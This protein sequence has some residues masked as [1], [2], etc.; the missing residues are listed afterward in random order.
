MQRKSII[1]VLIGV[2]IILLVPAVAMQ[3]T[4]EV[5]WA[6]FDF[7]AASALLISSGL[8]F[9]Y[10]SDRT[11]DIRHKA[12]IGVAVATVLFVIWLQLAARIL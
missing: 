7:L 4:D 8:V 11:N 2:T 9:V 3:F 6:P 10:L 12:A 1:R 5:R